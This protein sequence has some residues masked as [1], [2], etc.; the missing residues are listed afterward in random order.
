MINRLVCCSWLEKVLKPE[1]I[2]GRSLNK[3]EKHIN[4]KMPSFEIN[5]QADLKQNMK[6]L[7]LDLSGDFSGISKESLEI[8]S[9]LTKTFLKY[10]APFLPDGFLILP[11]FISP[12]L[13]RRAARGRQPPR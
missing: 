11:H 4:L 1:V 10:G 7:G 6:R 12:E 2:S 13:M 3:T 9:I 8:G 5:Y